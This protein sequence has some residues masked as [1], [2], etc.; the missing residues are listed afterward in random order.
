MTQAGEAEWAARYRP[1]W[2]LVAEREYR[3][4][5]L[6][7]RE[8]ISPA[9][10]QLI[11]EITTYF[12]ERRWGFVPAPRGWYVFCAIAPTPDPLA[13]LLITP[14]FGA[15]RGH[16]AEGHTWCNDTL[17]PRP[18]VMNL[19]EAEMLALLERQ[20][21]RYLAARAALAERL[22]ALRARREGPD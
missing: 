4:F 13:D 22:L 17:Q 12:P 8:N 3:G 14:A 11:Q 7:V 6:L 19:D 18:E 16:A 5:R 21:D 20:V 2:R 9:A 10:R 1:V 15:H